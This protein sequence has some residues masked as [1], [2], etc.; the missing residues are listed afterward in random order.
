MVEKEGFLKKASDTVG[1]FVQ[2]NPAVDF[3]TSHGP[4]SAPR[5]VV[6]ALA[7]GGE[8]AD[9]GL[10]TDAYNLLKGG[11]GLG[12]DAAGQPTV[13][14]NTEPTVAQNIAARS[15]QGSGG[16]V[17]TDLKTGKPDKAPASSIG[18]E[19]SAPIPEVLERALQAH[20]GRLADFKSIDYSARA[21]A[22]GIIADI[23]KETAQLTDE[24]Y[25]PAMEKMGAL[26][27][28]A[29]TEV[30][31]I[32]DYIEAARSNRINPGQFFAN[33]GGAGTF[34]AAIAIGAGAMAQT[35]AGG[36]PNAAH[37]IIQR[38]IDR[39][40]RAQ[41]VN[42]HHDR[43]MIS[44]QLNFANAIRGLAQ[45]QGSYANLVR[46]GLTAM[47]QTRIAEVS[48]GYSEVQNQ[49]ASKS[50]Y[51]MLAADGIQAK[52]KQIAS[53]RY[54]LNIGFRGWQQA[55]QATIAA[56]NA[57]AVGRGE[58][59]AAGGGRRAGG[60]GVPPS[61]AGGPARAGGGPR[62]PK[63]NFLA[64]AV[65]I[66]MGGPGEGPSQWD[67]LDDKGKAAH[68][69]RTIQR[70]ADETN[71]K[72]SIQM[73]RRLVAAFKGGPTDS[74]SRAIADTDDMA[75]AGRDQNP[76]VPIYIPGVGP[77]SFAVRDQA[78]WDKQDQKKISETLT[79]QMTRTAYTKRLRELVSITNVGGKFKEWA[80]LGQDHK[81]II[82]GFGNVTQAEFLAEMK[83]LQ[84]VIIADS[85]ASESGR[86][87]LNR[88]WEI[89]R[90]IRKT[91]VGETFLQELADL[92]GGR[93]AA[94]RAAHLDPF[95]RQS[96]DAVRGTATRAGLYVPGGSGAV[97]KSLGDQD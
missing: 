25:T 9:F 67:S 30:A 97:L 88:E 8:P 90:L 92:I 41:V 71:T 57:V 84:E 35:F 16:L 58:A 20:T 42:Q 14:P 51:D 95:I 93:T 49:I 46:I 80:R 86:N 28:T 69:A 96:E 4:L 87:A 73:K 78:T 22:F 13:A 5:T 64:D 23:H 45:D 59:P 7:P 10:A 66:A 36:G 26:L 47:A 60:R 3:V 32:E 27:T 61:A 50:L 18:V 68:L 77:G 83:G 33:V 82:P 34:A 1:E 6:E 48:A 85:I 24:Q 53:T 94:E 40:V 55:N 31:A 65:Q 72:V 29:E 63:G 43:A 91:G 75:F 81:I 37:L 62:Q 12:V 79:Q 19:Y 74:L 17:D 44:H 76:R 15:G 11:G 56:K 70:H 39:N 2:E 21:Q 54:K 38:A 89:D 52:M